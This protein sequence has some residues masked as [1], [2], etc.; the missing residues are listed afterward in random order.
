MNSRS[1]LLVEDDEDDAFFMR[2]ALT[3][4]HIDLPLHIAVNGQEALDYLGG[5]GQ[6]SDRTKH[7]LPAIVF[8]DLKLP[9]VHGFEVLKWIRSQ[10]SLNDVPV[11]ILTSSPEPR[12]R[13]KALQLG[14]KAY[15]VKPPTRDMVLTVLEAM[16]LAHVSRAS[17]VAPA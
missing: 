9:Y 15:L 6:F 11:I 12:D 14:A 17:L 1:I 10:P 3:K 4:A 13:E 8:L 16:H 2:R 5:I 7:P